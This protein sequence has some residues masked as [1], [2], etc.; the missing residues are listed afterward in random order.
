MKDNTSVSSGFLVIRQLS[1]IIAHLL[2]YF[3]EYKT[4]S[5]ISRTPTFGPKMGEFRYTQI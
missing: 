2:P 1:C 3:L 4:L 5:N